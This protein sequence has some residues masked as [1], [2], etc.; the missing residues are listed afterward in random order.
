MLCL[1]GLLQ[2]TTSLLAEHL[3]AMGENL[4]QAYKQPF[5]D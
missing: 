1:T 3:H 2:L 4:H 5:E